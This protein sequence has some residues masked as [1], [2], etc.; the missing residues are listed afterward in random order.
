MKAF[1]LAVLY[2]A[3]LSSYMSTLSFAAPSV[4]TGPVQQSNPAAVGTGVLVL[5]RLA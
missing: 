5:D 3:A 4:P 2:T 1:T